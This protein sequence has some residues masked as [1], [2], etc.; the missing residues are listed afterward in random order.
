[1]RSAESVAEALAAVSA[2]LSAAE[3]VRRTNVFAP[4]TSSA[5]PL[6]VALWPAPLFTAWTTLESSVCSLA[7]RRSTVSMAACSGANTV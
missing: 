5:W 2:M 3:L 4:A 1:M 7:C 6:K